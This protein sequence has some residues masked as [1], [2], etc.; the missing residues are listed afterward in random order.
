MA[1]AAPCPNLETLLLLS[2]GQLPE[3]QAVAVKEHLESCVSC[4]QALRSNGQSNGLK[5][6][7]EDLKS[8]PVLPEP[9][10]K[11]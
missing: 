9:W 8:E 5:P 3:S 7:M 1:G 2:S 10:R 6:N 11:S 4:T